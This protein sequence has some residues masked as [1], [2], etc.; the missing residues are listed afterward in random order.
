[1]AKSLRSKW[2]RKMRAEKRK[3]NAPK[4]L[5][6]LKQA[7]SLDKKGEAVMTDMQE[8]ATVVPADKIKKQT[9]V[10]M[11]EVEGDEGKMDM[12][13]KRNKKTLLDENGQYPVWMNQRQAKKLKGKRM[14]KKGGQGKKKKGIAW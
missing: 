6:R 3:K 14:G 11:G 12:D 4:E 7:L 13:S 10:D 9:D 2:K 8:I 5:A 1:M